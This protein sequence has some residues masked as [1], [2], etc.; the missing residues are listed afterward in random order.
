[1]EVCL[2]QA[3]CILPR[4][5]IMPPLQVPW[6]EEV[7]KKLRAPMISG[8]IDFALYLRLFLLLLGEHL[9]RIAVAASGVDPETINDVA[10]MERWAFLALFAGFF[11]RILMGAY[12]ELRRTK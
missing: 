7:A 1:M 2:M 3:V 10:W 12:N 4:E 6:W 11:I 8:V 5:T 9:I